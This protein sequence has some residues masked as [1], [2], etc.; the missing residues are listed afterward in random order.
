MR[1]GIYH[2]QVLK[3]LA[4]EPDIGTKALTIGSVTHSYA[5]NLTDDHPKLL[6]GPEVDGRDNTGDV[7]PF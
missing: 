1:R 7:A 4:I 2:S 5:V 6:F 3:A